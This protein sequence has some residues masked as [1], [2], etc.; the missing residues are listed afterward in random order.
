[1]RIK[2]G[3]KMSKIS[4][5]GKKVR[6]F[7][8]P[9]IIAHWTNAF[10]FFMLYLTGLPLYTE[11]FDWLYVVFGGPAG[12]RLVHRIAGV[13]FVIPVLFVLLTD[14]KGFFHWIK[15]MFTWKK[16][17]FQ[18]FLEFPKEFF[19]KHANVPKQDFYNAGEKINSLLTI[20]TAIMLIGSGF[21]MWFPKFFPSTMV[22]WAYPIHNLGFGLS[23][24]VVVGHIYLSV[25][26]PNSRPSMEGITKGNVDIEY[27]KEHH[28]RWYDE[29]MEEDKQEKMKKDA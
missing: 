12:A 26:H 21:I 2:E 24:A 6:R 1:M 17:D 5:D 7:S 20:L 27:A 8:K 25:G 19:G 28:G 11:F 23:A 18:F 14:P 3:M 22:M 4:S 10:A 9:I 16:H 15:Q 13:T 29:L